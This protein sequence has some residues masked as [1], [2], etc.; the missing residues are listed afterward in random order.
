MC[1]YYGELGYDGYTNFEGITSV[2]NF[3][4]AE[5]T[6]REYIRTP[7]SIFASVPRQRPSKFVFKSTS[8]SAIRK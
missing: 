6:E 5:G 7:L 8:F 4:S 1:A 2:Q 3:V